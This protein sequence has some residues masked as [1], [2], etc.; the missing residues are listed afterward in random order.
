MAKARITPIRTKTNK[1]GK[2]VKLVAPPRGN[3]G[4]SRGGGASKG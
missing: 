3:R 4:N 2:K 1:G